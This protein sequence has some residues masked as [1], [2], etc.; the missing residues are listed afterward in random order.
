MSDLWNSRLVWDECEWRPLRTDS[1]VGVDLGQT[2]D[3]S[4]VA[5]IQQTEKPGD[6]NAATFAREIE[7]RRDVNHLEKMALGTPYPDVVARLCAII[8]SKA[9]ENTNRYLVVDTSGVGRPVVD[10]LE[11]QNL[12]CRILRVTMTGGAGETMSKG[13]YRVP[14]RDLVT[15]LA[16]KL[17]CGELR[18][19]NGL[20]EGVAL[21]RELAAMRVTMTSAGREKFGAKSGEHDDLVMAASLGVWALEKVSRRV[22]GVWGRQRI[23]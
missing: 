15:G 22:P 2:T 3:F 17:Q 8:R 21:V 11:R 9:L 18:I 12:P 23:V 6:W 20:K 5:I 7:V 19:A 16:L 4:A 13:E 10:L 1:I 14:K